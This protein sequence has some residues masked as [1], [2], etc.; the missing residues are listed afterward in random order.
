MSWSATT[1]LQ[2]SDADSFLVLSAEDEAGESSSLGD[3]TAT[4]QA[5][6][7]IEKAPAS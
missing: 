2:F 3:S 4:G 1:A 6:I 5:K 7:T